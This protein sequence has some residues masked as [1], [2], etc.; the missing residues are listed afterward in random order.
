V[1][2]QNVISIEGADAAEDR[3]FDSPERGVF[4]NNN[5]LT[6]ITPEAYAEVEAKIE[7]VRCAPR[8][9]IF[10]EDDPGDCLYLIAQGSVK[11]S[12]KGRGGQQ[13]T[14]AF[15]MEQDF[16]GEMALIDRGQRSAQATAV[17]HAILGRVDRQTW[18]LLLRL[19]P[20][21]VLSNFTK[22]V[23]K[24]LRDNN[25]HFIDEMMRNERL[26]LLGTTISSIVHD[27]NNPIGCILG[28]CAAIQS[29]VQDE[30]THQMARII[31]E[32]VT[33]METMTRELI[34]FS[35]GKTELHL[36]FVQ[37]ADLIEGLQPDFAKCRPFVDVQTE[38]LYEG[39]LQVDRHR[40]LRV[41]SNLIRNAREAMKAEPGNRL[42][43]SV[44]PVDSRVRF[45]ISDTGCGIPSELLPRIFEPFVTHGKAN[46]TGLGLAISKAV[47]EAHQGT[48][49]VSS[50]DKGT[51]FQ[52]DLP[53]TR[54]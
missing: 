17:G 24:R 44:K 5:L 11:I 36:Q 43:L 48:I 37:V 6:E 21:E 35:R 18:D 49:A 22:S 16:F 30:L 12:K 23:T 51:T 31:R 38:I 32:S 8:E 47:V 13:E 27:M 9:V 19:A 50:S 2:P 42:R 28:A 45:E 25:Q 10:A 7:V 3:L 41:F 53:L 34:D 54:S 15:L 29:T 33:R 14:L 4:R 26:S 46:G 1:Q 40:F 20:N 52:I 39:Q